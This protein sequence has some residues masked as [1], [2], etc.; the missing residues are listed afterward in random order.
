MFIVIITSTSQ[1]WIN[2]FVL[3]NKINF[4]KVHTV[5]KIYISLFLISSHYIKGNVV[6]KIVLFWGLHIQLYIY[7]VRIRWDTGD[8]INSS[9][10]VRKGLCTYIITIQ[11]VFLEK[12]RH[13]FPKVTKITTVTLW[14][15]ENSDFCMY[16]MKKCRGGKIRA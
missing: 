4:I 13:V 12:S 9:F 7:T 14:R 1:L 15:S 6:N 5:G 16:E 10:F 3:K 8:E 2:I 11:I